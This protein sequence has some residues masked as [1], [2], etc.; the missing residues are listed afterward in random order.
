MQNR[1]SIATAREISSIERKKSALQAMK[2][3]VSSCFVMFYAQ[4]VWFGHV[5]RKS[6]QATKDLHAGEDFLAI[7]SRCG[8]IDLKNCE[9]LGL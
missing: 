9:A 4:A 3:S 5:P 2:E 1:I 7:R 8:A 6:Q